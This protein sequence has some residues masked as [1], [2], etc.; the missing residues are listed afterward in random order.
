MTYY[1]QTIMLGWADNISKIK[2]GVIALILAL[3]SLSY[4]IAYGGVLV[5]LRNVVLDFVM[6]LTYFTAIAAVILGTYSWRKNKDNFGLLGLS[7]VVL[8]VLGYFIL[9]L[10][11]LAYLPS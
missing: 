5:D 3:F 7:L 2:M 8:F 1:S 6:G 4:W 11:V 9:L 10:Y